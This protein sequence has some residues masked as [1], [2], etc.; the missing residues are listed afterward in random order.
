MIAVTSANCL[1]LEKIKAGLVYDTSLEFKNAGFSF[2]CFCQLPAQTD[3][4]SATKF[5]TIWQ[6]WFGL[7]S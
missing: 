4:V 1:Q 6:W 3:C 2:A 7:P 5:C